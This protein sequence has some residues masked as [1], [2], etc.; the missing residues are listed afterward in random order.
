MASLSPEQQLL[1]EVCDEKGLSSWLTV[2][3]RFQDGT[4]LKKTYFRD[5]LCIRYGRRLVGLPDTCVCGAELTAR[6]ALT[7]TTGGYMIA[8]HNE[9]RDLIAHLLREAGTVD[10]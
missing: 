10:W 4:V 9:V 8:R 6:H 2:V 7:H 3:P 1:V 5:A